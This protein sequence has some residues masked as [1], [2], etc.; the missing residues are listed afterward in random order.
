MARQASR[1]TKP[2]A[3]RAT[4]AGKPPP[5]R[6]P[7][8]PGPWLRRFFWAAGLALALGA[9]ILYWLAREAAAIDIS[10]L[11][12]VPERTQIYDFRG[13]TVGVLHGENR[14]FI[15]LTEVPVAFKEALLAREDTRFYEHDGVDWFGVLRAA[16][17]NVTEG[18]IVQGPAP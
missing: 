1:P 14:I 4:R 15:P 10:Q 11:N 18:D 3:D 7:K 6:L 8:P 2:R 5:R 12:Q 13:R 9:G 16:F 17:R